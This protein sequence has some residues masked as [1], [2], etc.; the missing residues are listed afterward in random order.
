MISLI[1]TDLWEESE[2][3]KDGIS[4]TVLQDGTRGVGEN[5]LMW[6]SLPL[7]LFTLRIYT[8]NLRNLLNLVDRYR[9]KL[10][11]IWSIIWITRLKI[12]NLSDRF[13]KYEVLI[14]FIQYLSQLVL[15]PEG[16]TGDTETCENEHKSP[17]DGTKRLE[18]C[19]DSHRDHDNHCKNMFFTV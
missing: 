7:V 15:I 19:I 18:Y 11:W 17:H 4:S 14:G 1:I 10:W 9:H 8:H 12:Y 6:Y 16:E 2:L 13:L 5:L 3:C